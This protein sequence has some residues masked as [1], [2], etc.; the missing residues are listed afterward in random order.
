MGFPSTDTLLVFIPVL[1]RVGGILMAGPLWRHGRIPLPVKMGVT[2]MATVA[3][4]PHF[5]TFTVPQ[6]D[7]L[8]PLALLV[9]K[10]LATGVILGVTANLVFAGVE[11]AGQMV[12]VAMG[13]AIVNVIDPVYNVHISIISR[14]HG[15]FALAIFFAIDAHHLLFRAV[16]SSYKVVPLGEFAMTSMTMSHMVDMGFG[17]FLIGIRI[18][19]PA[20]AVLLLTDLTMGLVARTVPQ[21]N[22]FI[23]GFPLR[24]GLGF[25]M[26]TSTLPIVV[27]L[28]EGLFTGLER[29]FSVLLRGM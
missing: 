7:G 27:R 22:V 16:V 2:L 1:F 10:E 25:M 15:L 23:V 28:L 20:L 12:G 29:D 6:I 8:L 17:I 26:I 4:L 21:M 13:L 3:M 5:S 9:A 19:A 24:I 18:A 14:L 11:F